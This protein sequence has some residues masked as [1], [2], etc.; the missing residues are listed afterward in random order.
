MPSWISAVVAVAALLAAGAAYFKDEGAKEQAMRSEVETLKKQI[1][2]LATK[3]QL[4]D[5]EAQIP[6]HA[7]VVSP[8]LPEDA[9]LII[10]NKNGCPQGWRSYAPAKGKF[11]LGAGVG[12][13]KL[14]V[15]KSSDHAPSAS[16]TL[17]EH[18][19]GAQNGRETHKLSVEEMPK[20]HHKVF[21]RG[22][23]AV[24][25]EAMAVDKDEGNPAMHTG[26][27][28]NGKGHNNMPPFIA[29]NF[30]MKTG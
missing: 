6:S 27:E 23:L 1:S 19:Y 15:R 4:D 10:A 21:R 2:T 11:I 25:G 8:A 30:C 14:E 17:S 22:N 5:V 9:V 7:P 24:G 12:T 16:V 3:T 20:H 18:L 13:G 26:S 28:G 29:L